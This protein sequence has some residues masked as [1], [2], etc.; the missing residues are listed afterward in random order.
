MK[1]ILKTTYQCERC[2]SIHIEEDLIMQY[3]GVEFCDTCIDD[4][5]FYDDKTYGII[6]LPK[7]N[8][9]SLDRF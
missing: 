7:E 4:F 8:V 5:I 9:F 1:E 2:G 3:N 6:M